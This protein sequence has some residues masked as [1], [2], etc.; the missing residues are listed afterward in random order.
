[1]K[2]FRRSKIFKALSLSLALVVS[3]SSVLADTRIGGRTIQDTDIVNYDCTDNTPSVAGNDKLRTYCDQSEGK[4]K[5][6]FDGS[7]YA[8][9]GGGG[10]WGSITG[11]LADQ[12]DLQAALDAK[13]PTSRT[14]TINSTTQDL[15]ANR[16]WNVGTVTGT[17]LAGALA[18]WAS[19]TAVGYVASSFY[20]SASAMLDL[21]ASEGSELVTGGDF[22]SGS[23]WTAPTGWSITGG[24]A[25]HTANG[26]GA[27]T[28]SVTV[29][30]GYRYRLSYDVLDWTAGTVTLTAGGNTFTARSSNSTYT[31]YFIAT[32][33]ATVAATPSNTA[34]FSLDNVSLK[35]LTG[36]VVHAGSVY[37]NG[38]TIGANTSN[39]SPGTTRHISLKNAGGNTYID[40]YFGNSL[41]G[42]LGWNS[43]GIMN[44]YAQSASHYFYGGALSSPTLY[45]YFSSAGMFTQYL[46]GAYGGISA[47]STSTSQPSKLSVWGRAGF[48]HTLLYQ[49]T[50]LTNEYTYVDVDADSASSCG[51]T[52]TYACGHWTN[53]TDCGLRDSHGG[54]TWS[55]IDCSAYNYEW[56]MTTCLATPGCTAAEVDC[57]TSG[58]YDQT[59][60]ESADDSYGGNCTYNNSPIEC[61]TF[62]PTDQFTCEG[63]GCSYYDNSCSSY[64]GDSSG[65]E[66]NGCV[67]DYGS[68]TC[69]GYCSGTVD[70]Y[71]C[72]GQYYTG[73]CGGSG[74]NCGGSSSCAGITTSGNC[75]S[76]AGCSWTAGAVLTMPSHSAFGVSFWA[77]YFIRNIGT[78]ANI[79]VVPNTD[80]T[81][82]GTTSLSVSAKNWV[83][84]S[85]AYHQLAC[86]SW[87]NTSTSTCQTGHTG[88]TYTECS[89]LDESTCMSVGGACS[90]DSMGMTC[91]GGG[92]CD[93]TW[94]VIRDWSVYGRS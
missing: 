23:G 93:G 12:T 53:E 78:T 77:T 36:G 86:S 75:G 92:N 76:E 48:K 71:S 18:Y 41:L 28:R 68:T 24:K 52:I 15:S 6:S 82:N 26:T 29:T 1:M 17:G 43:S 70:N 25:Q 58:W 60:C 65:C 14:I 38:L 44:Y 13:T 37:T 7:A 84:L 49:N 31:E 69:Y 81:V 73:E 16:T 4:L 45:H 67:Y 72:D 22:A 63:Y 83:H 57:S 88:C 2:F 64:N 56:G 90:W 11:T 39:S 46:V 10:A 33:S 8:P 3:S 40:S 66:S 74:G 54:C 30:N 34:R 51:G 87:S 91:T 89:G 5:Y 32:S 50:T 55:P 42:A 20:T 80:Q 59:S 61:T 21:W 35:Q 9:L 62:N 94:T 19:T 47:G 79:T 27:L 85:F